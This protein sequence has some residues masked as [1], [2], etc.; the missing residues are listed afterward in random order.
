VT[1]KENNLKIKHI[2]WV[3]WGLLTVLVVLLFAA[4]SRAWALQQALREKEAV[5]I[6][7]LTAQANEYATLEAQLTYVQS[8]EYVGAWAQGDA[9]MVHPEETLVIPLIS[10]ATPTPTPVP[11]STPIPTPT[12]KPFWQRWWE[13]IKGR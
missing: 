10:T 1:K 13:Q 4:F 8:D 3:L 12:P 5:L 6:P 9:R 11:T 2:S 7:M